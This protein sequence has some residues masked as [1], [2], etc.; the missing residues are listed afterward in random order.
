MSSF[1][2]LLREVRVRARLTQK[3]LAKIVHADHTYISKME[4]FCQLVS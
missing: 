2:E 4:K 1:G 3:E